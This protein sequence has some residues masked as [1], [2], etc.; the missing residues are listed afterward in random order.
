MERKTVGGLVLAWVGSLVLGGCVVLPAVTPGGRAR[1]GASGAFG[2]TAGHSSV[3][4]AHTGV[5]PLTLVPEIFEGDFELGYVGD[6]LLEGDRQDDAHGAY[7]GG[8]YTPLLGELGNRTYLRGIA[9]LDVDVMTRR[10]LAVV[11]GTASVGIELF[12]YVTGEGVLGDLRAGVGGVMAG[13]W[14]VGLQLQGAYR[15]VEGGESYGHLGVTLSIRFPAAAGGVYGTALLAL[16]VATTD[17]RGSGSDG[18]W[19]DISSGESRSHPMRGAGEGSP[20]GPRWI[21]EDHAGN[22]GDGP[23]RLDARRLCGAETC[24]CRRGDRGAEPSSDPPRP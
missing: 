3:M 17:Q 15:Y 8:A 5:S 24:E 11:G 9:Q 7:A 19:G 23:T 6:V 10:G 14:G 16:D 4:T 22:R 21:C 18:S 1:L 2:D 12:G 13:Q 20:A